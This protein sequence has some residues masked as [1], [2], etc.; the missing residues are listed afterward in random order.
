MDAEPEI[1]NHN[2]ETVPRL[3]R[4][5]RPQARPE[6]SLAV[7]RMAKEMKPAG[8][9]KSGFMVGL[10]ETWDEILQVM[11]D[12][13]A[14][15]VDILTIGQYLQPSKN[16]LPIER[17]YHPDEFVELANEGHQRGF[18]MGRVGAAGAV[19]VSCGWAGEDHIG[20]R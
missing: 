17:Y 8:L 14:V 16:H 1:L 6:R 10:G 7:L 20:T 5:V 2:T 3:S 15:D 9:T 12:L 19:V 18:K 13:R 4:W 11:D